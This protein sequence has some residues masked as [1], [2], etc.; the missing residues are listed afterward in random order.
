MPSRYPF[1]AP[2]LVIVLSA[3]AFA[4]GGLKS[5]AVCHS[6]P[7][8]TAASPA[9]KTSF[10]NDSLFKSGNFRQ[11]SSPGRSPASDA[12]YPG[13]ELFVGYSHVRFGVPGDSQSKSSFDFQG[14]AVSLAY[15]LN[16]WL[17]LSGEASLYKIS[18]L[19]SATSATYLFGPKFSRRIDRFTLYLNALF[20]GARLSSDF[21]GTPSNTFFG[22]GSIHTQAFATALGGGLDVKLRRHLSWRVLQGDYLLTTFNRGNI[23]RQNNIRA[24]TGLVFRFGERRP[25]NHP[26]SLTLTA[27]PSEVVSG[28]GGYAVL[29]ANAADPDNDP[30]TYTWFAGGG[31]IEGTGAEVRWNPGGAPPGVYEIRSRVD[32]GRGGVAE[33]S[34][35]ITVKPPPN[36]PPRVSCAASLQTVVAGQPITITAQGSDPDNDQLTFTFAAAGK[37]LPASSSFAT[38]DTAGLAAGDYTVTCQ[39]DDG[40]GGFSAANVDIEIEAPKQKRLETRLSLHS[41]YF[42][43]GMPTEDDPSGG[44]LPSQKQTLL[45]L[46]HDFKQYLAFRPEAHLMLEGHADPRGGPAYNNVLSERRVQRTKEF[47]LEHGISAEAIETEALGIEQPMSVGQVK[48][49]VQKDANLTPEQKRWLMRRL[50]GVALAQ[51]R[52]VDVTLSTTGESSLRQFPFNAEDALN[53]IRRRRRAAA[54]SA[55]KRNRFLH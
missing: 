2:V 32:D 18:A 30:L 39:A 42:P 54:K 15:N 45:T 49:T 5:F 33:S 31:E 52:R 51:S 10:I 6:Q 55:G 37:K 43:T 4:S 9:V 34:T 8:R 20:G 40:H 7:S 46:A 22:A 44:F 47:L 50:H 35:R 38:F 12:T 3:A 53:L 48:Q 24:G 1:C 36:R 28:S 29:R 23:S 13:L 21:S 25:P 11:E 26:P 16:R 17:G 41:I 14:G 27:L 19:P